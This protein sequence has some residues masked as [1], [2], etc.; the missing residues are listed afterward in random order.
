MDSNGYLLCLDASFI[1]WDDD[2]IG[3][4]EWPH[5]LLRISWED[6]PSDIDVISPRTGAIVRFNR[7]C[8]CPVYHYYEGQMPGTVLRAGFYIRHYLRESIK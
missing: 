8:S 2:R 6:P 4:I 1:E 5:D 7:V 3:A